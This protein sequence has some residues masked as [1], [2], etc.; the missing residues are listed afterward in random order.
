MF[1]NSHKITRRG[2]LG[3]LATMG[4]F[5]VIG[6]LP[7]AAF[8]NVPTVA[9]DGRKLN[10]NEFEVTVNVFHKGN[11]MFH[12]VDQVVLYADG[13]EAKVWKYAW[14]KRPESENFSVTER[15]RVTQKT[16]FSAMAN[17]NL[18]GKNKEEG[19]LELSP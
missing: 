16:V 19:R 15:V 8:A 12:Y 6:S 14:N 7:K 17:C 18:H 11:S 10:G 2:F 3:Q 5:F 4:V 9:L 13:E 1:E